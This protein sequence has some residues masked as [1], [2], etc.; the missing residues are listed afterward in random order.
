M[1]GSSS[2][3]NTFKLARRTVINVDPAVDS[4]LLS[5]RGDGRA[6]GVVVNRLGSG[7]DADLGVFQ[8]NTCFKRGCERTD[9]SFSGEMVVGNPVANKEDGTFSITLPAGRYNATLVTDG[10]P[11]TAKLKL[12]GLSRSLSLRPTTPTRPIFSSITG[13]SPEQ[14]GHVYSTGGRSY[15]F[16]APTYLFEQSRYVTLAGGAIT[17]GTCVIFGEAPPNHIYLP[18]CPTLSPGDNRVGLYSTINAPPESVS[19]NTFATASLT[20]PLPADQLISVGGYVVSATPLTKTDRMQLAVQL[21]Q[22][23]G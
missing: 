23:A 8:A 5:V 11:V 20:A 1:S 6:V 19:P 7:P 14:P 22:R 2:G 18:T 17:D 9:A 16:N 4:P 10:A 13:V 12:S 15:T 3:Y 21:P